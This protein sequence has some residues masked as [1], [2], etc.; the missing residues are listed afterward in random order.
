MQTVAFCPRRPSFF[1]QPLA[2]AGPKRED[3]SAK[4][5]VFGNDILPEAS[6]IV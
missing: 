3:A 2:L 4:M 6:I 5:A 1:A